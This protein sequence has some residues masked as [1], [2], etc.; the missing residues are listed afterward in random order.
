MKNSIALALA[1]L[2]LPVSSFAAA[3]PVPPSAGGGGIQAALDALP[4]AGGEVLLSAGQYVI[5]QPI[6]L[7]KN[8]QALRGSGEATVL[9]LADGA[10]CPVVVLGS[11]FTQATTP[12][13]DI[14]LSR[15]FIDG[16]RKHQDKEVWRILGNGAGLYNNGVDVWNINGAVVDQVVCCRCRSG[17]MVT[18]GATRRLTV[19]DYTAFD[20]QF[21]GL[22]CYFTEDS[23][24]SRM[25]L[26]D[27]LSAGISLDL[28]FNHNIIHDSILTG[29]DLGVFM[30]Q[31][32]GNTFDGLTIKKSHHHG[33]FMAQS[34]A[35]ARPCPGSECAGNTFDNIQ[36]TNCGGKGFLVNDA[37]CTNNV[38]CGAQFTDDAQGGLGQA[39]PNLVALRTAP[40]H[41]SPLA[42]EAIALPLIR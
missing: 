20:N 21:D 37:T 33:V 15:L 39:V 38:I 18:A 7:R 24:F 26:H 4:A 40:A 16:N 9:Y 14:R 17:G 2:V 25:D 3:V 27:N 11:P 30:R 22:A 8:R 42:V 32:C 36:V 28:N 19:R 1:C 12:V 23:D 10:D 31:S 6:M 13:K 34:F 29:N 35:G 41:P 5:H